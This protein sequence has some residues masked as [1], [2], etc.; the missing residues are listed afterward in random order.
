MSQ[1]RS[2]D[3]FCSWMESNSIDI[4]FDAVE[5]RSS[6]P[7]TPSSDWSVFAKTDVEEGTI[8]AWIPNSALLSPTNSDL[9]SILETESVESGL[10]LVITLAYERSLKEK[11]KW[12]GYLKSLPER[13]N[14]P[15][16]WSDEELAPL[17]CTPLL[18]SVHQERNTMENDY[19]ETVKPLLE[20]YPQQ[21]LEG[22]LT[23]ED[24]KNAASLVFSRDFYVDSEIGRALVPFADIFNHKCCVVADKDHILQ[25]EALDSNY[26]PF[27]D[28]DDDDNEI[29]PEL[30][31]EII[32][33]SIENS[34]GVQGLEIKAAQF[35]PKRNEIHNTYGELSNEYLLMNYGF[36]LAKNPFN[37]ITIDANM[38]LAQLQNS[39]KPLDASTITKIQTLKE[40]LN[41]EE[42]DCFRLFP[43][44]KCC[45]LL[46]F[47]LE[48][49]F[50][51]K[52][53]SVDQIKIESETESVSTVI[54]VLSKKHNK[55][56]SRILSRLLR[57]YQT[58]HPLI[59]VLFESS[60]EILSQ[61]IEYLDSILEK[62]E[63]TNHAVS[64]QQ[65]DN[66]V[67]SLQS[68]QSA[69]MRRK[70]KFKEIWCEID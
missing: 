46:A 61:S 14:L 18:E 65:E 50:S 40:I 56:L 70:R 27:D 13:E 24:F 45:T 34:E 53:P 41:G 66:G 22:S 38:L 3:S 23:V 62:G 32:V 52:S 8:L 28:D 47:A 60:R 64:L 63:L 57:A 37:R 51:E 29:D 4:N 44:G 10:S 5:I 16:F 30:K 17:K 26:N 20:K 58:N 19:K 69:Q 6:N 48:F 15:V 42:T 25:V 49:L 9:K 35:I 39:L 2:I 67:Q 7:N 68:S 54:P 55:A 59:G 12:F 36:C 21:F 31:L 43:K 1:V 33:C 11:S